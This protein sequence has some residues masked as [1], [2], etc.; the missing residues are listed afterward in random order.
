MTQ[1][2]FHSCLKKMH[3]LHKIVKYKS[4]WNEEFYNHTYK[5]DCSNLKVKVSKIIVRFTLILEICKNRKKM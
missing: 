4:E 1:N 2:D 3:S 5:E